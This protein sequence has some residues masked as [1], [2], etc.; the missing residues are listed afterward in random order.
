MLNIMYLISAT[1]VTSNHVSVVFDSAF[2]YV[3]TTEIVVV[4]HRTT[5]GMIK[6]QKQKTKKP[7]KTTEIDYTTSNAPLYFMKNITAIINIII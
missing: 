4:R 2:V 6:K 5:F 1:L 3:A 7:K